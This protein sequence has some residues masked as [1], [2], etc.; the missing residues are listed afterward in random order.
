MT[1][2]VLLVPMPDL[3][4]VSPF[5]WKSMPSTKPVLRKDRRVTGKT[6]AQ[7]M[8]QALRLNTLYQQGMPMATTGEAA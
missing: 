7:R 2:K 6:P 1:T 8:E 4:V 3:V 5:F